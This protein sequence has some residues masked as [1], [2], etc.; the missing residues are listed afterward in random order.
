MTLAAHAA[1]L[2]NDIKKL[3]QLKL[4]AHQLQEYQNRRDKLNEKL[5]ALES[6]VLFLLALAKREP[7]S[8]QVGS[9]KT[10]RDAFAATK[11]L[12]NEFGA[13]VEVLLGDDFPALMKTLEAVRKQIVD[14]AQSSWNAYAG[15]RMA[16]LSKELLDALDRID[17]FKKTV[18]RLRESQ[19]PIDTLAGKSWVTELELD[20][21]DQL[22]KQRNEVWEELKG[23]GAIPETVVDFL[24][25]CN[26][27]GVQLDALTPEIVNWLKNREILSC[28]RVIL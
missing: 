20:T 11:K 17:V 25:R 15:P 8:P 27:G 19:G 16:A 3:T 7:T 6:P 24:K 28:F 12:R 1:A 26:K 14:D 9:P 22:V 18:K 10:L 2:E 13:N 4:A 5:T 21:F 23:G